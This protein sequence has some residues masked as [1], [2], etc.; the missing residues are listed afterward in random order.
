MPRNH[1]HS[2]SMN[3]A[4]K[5]LLEQ[6]VKDVAVLKQQVAKIE[7][8]I[9]T[10]MIDETEPVQQAAPVK[11]VKPIPK[12]QQA[13]EEP[14]LASLAQGNVPG[15]YYTDGSCDPNPGMG[16]W[17]FIQVVDNEPVDKRRGGEESTTN[18]RMELTAIIMAY[19]HAMRRGYKTLIIR[20]D[21]EWCMKCF[22]GEYTKKK[23]LDLWAQ[24]DA[25][26]AKYGVEP[27]FEKVKAHSGDRFNE[28]VDKLADVR[29]HGLT[30][31]G[32]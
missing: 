29:I 12:A 19:R 31:I 8:C 15:L 17:G 23:N 26:I 5:A 27:D 4:K 32:K 11:Q 28:M 21:S 20:T 18:N 24:L 7:E 9:A 14:G 1:S 13:S 6:L 10:L 3:A 30:S 2:L 25:A 16:G 22:T